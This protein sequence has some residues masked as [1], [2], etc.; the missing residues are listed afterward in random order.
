MKKTTVTKLPELAAWQVTTLRLTAFLSPAARVSENTWWSDLIGKSPESRNIR[1]QKGE[2]KDEGPFEQGKIVL[3]VN[4]A[5]V[6]WIFVPNIDPEKFEGDMLTVGSFP[7]VADL[8]LKLMQRWLTPPM[9]PPIQRLAFG[10]ILHQPVDGRTK[11][12]HLLDDYLP[13]LEIDHKNSSDLLYQINRPRQNKCG[14]KDLLI[15]RLSK[16]SVMSVQFFGIPVGQASATKMLGPENFVCNVELDINTDKD[17]QNELP[18]EQL[19][20]IFQELVDLAREIASKG[21]IS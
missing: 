12:Y 1:P 2:Q 5:R 19:P 21:D 10:A 17:F 13:A 20:V 14:I 11:G 9:C 4:P 6:D 18:R 7:E 3:N 8:F 16:W 15:N